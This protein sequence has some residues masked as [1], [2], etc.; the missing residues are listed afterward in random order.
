MW[1]HSSDV[2][3]SALNRLLV[4]CRDEAILLMAGA[5]NGRSSRQSSR[6]L[7]RSPRKVVLRVQHG[8]S[9]P[10]A[11][12]LEVEAENADIRAQRSD[13]REELALQLWSD[14][15]GQASDSNDAP[16]V[17]L[18]PPLD[19]RRRRGGFRRIALLASRE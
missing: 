18:P 1:N 4:A 15:G 5:I 12:G 13:V 3:H 17:E 6:L 19:W 11:P 14:D 7:R 9:R 10:R 16:S 2:A 8:T